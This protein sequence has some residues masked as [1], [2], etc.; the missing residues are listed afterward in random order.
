MEKEAEHCVN[1]GFNER[2]RDK[3]KYCWIFLKDRHE[4]HKLINDDQKMLS[5]GLDPDYEKAAFV[6]RWGDHLHKS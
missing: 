6:K 5:L 3:I 1:C 2:E 4:Q